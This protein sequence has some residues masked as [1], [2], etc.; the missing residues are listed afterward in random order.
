MRYT[1]ENVYQHY[2]RGAS[3]IQIDGIPE[4]FSFKYPDLIIGG[5]V[6]WGKFKAFVPLTDICLSADTIEELQDLYKKKHG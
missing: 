5:K 3:P 4:G 6:H 1:R 2:S